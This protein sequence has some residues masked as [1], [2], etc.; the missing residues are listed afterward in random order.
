ML[1]SATDRR[2]RAKRGRIPNWASLVTLQ[3]A[4]ME[5]KGAPSSQLTLW[6]K[7]GKRNR[8]WVFEKHTNDCFLTVH[9]WTFTTGVQSER[10]FGFE[11]YFPQIFYLLDLCSHKCVKCRRWLNTRLTTYPA[12]V[13]LLSV[14]TTVGYVA[15]SL[16]RECRCTQDCS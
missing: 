8:W 10:T 1:F 14:C 9:W 6:G 7:R 5:Q 16:Q 12:L 13:A 11:I 2:F 3:E 4:M 15:K